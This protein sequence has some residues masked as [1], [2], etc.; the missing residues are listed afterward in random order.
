MKYA[1]CPNRR[2]KLDCRDVYIAGGEI[3]DNKNLRTVK[4][5]KSN[6]KK[7]LNCGAAL[8]KALDSRGRVE[9]T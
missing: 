8:L 7:C 2:K 5:P 1:V 3:W 4:V 9:D 6:F